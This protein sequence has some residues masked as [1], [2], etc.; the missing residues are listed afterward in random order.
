MHPVRMLATMGL[1][2]VATV[3]VLFGVVILK[4]A[5]RSSR[6]AAQDSADPSTRTT[7][8]TR[9]ADEFI[10]GESLRKALAKKQEETGKQPE[11]S[12]DHNSTPVP[13]GSWYVAPI[14]ARPGT[15]TASDPDKNPGREGAEAVLREPDVPFGPIKTRF[16]TYRNK[17][18][19]DLFMA[20]PSVKRRIE[21]LLGANYN[22]FMERMQT[23]TEFTIFKGVLFAVGCKA[24]GC[25]VEEAFLLITLSDGTLHCAI[26]SDSYGGK[27]KTFSED[28]AHFPSAA[29]DYAIEH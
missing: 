21:D 18:P 20:E 1:A 23:E 25:T 15:G 22:F 14:E 4:E 27:L 19:S 2:V 12:A 8:G 17:Y 26:H 6:G 29:L 24:H 11:D 28:P 5:I 9:S 7:E 3:V 13:P 16:D 10:S